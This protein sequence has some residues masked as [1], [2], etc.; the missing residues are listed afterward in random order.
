[1]TNKKVKI[2]KGRQFK[3][4][5]SLIITTILFISVYVALYIL[6]SIVASWWGEPDASD[7]LGLVFVV[8][9][10]VPLIYAMFIKYEK[11]GIKI[12][13]KDYSSLFKMVKEVSDDVGVKMPS[14]IRLLPT[15]EIYV[16]GVFKKHI[17]IGIVALR[18][19][20]KEQL[21]AILYHEFGHFYGN[22][23]VIGFMLANIQISLEKSSKFGKAWWENMP[24]MELALVGVFISLFAKI[25]SFI[26]RTII[27]IYSRQVEY[28]ADCVASTFSKPDVFGKALLNYSAYTIYFGQ[29]GY[30]SIVAMLQEGKAYK[31][32]YEVISEDYKGQKPEKV[33]AIILKSDKGHFFSSH[34]SLKSRIKAIGSNISK[35]KIDVRPSANSLSLINKPKKLEEEFTKS[36]TNH[37]H[38]NLLYQDA[39]AR[40][41]MCK[42]CEEQFEKLE[43]L[44][45]H[46]ARC[47]GRP[48]EER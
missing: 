46:E 21:K 47:K 23:T 16:T 4:Y 45:E 28:R 3:V 40:E 8:I 14:E 39:V 6:G 13:K 26:F 37:M 25:Y 20:P 29:I 5:L 11:G 44:L 31:D 41:G 34:P 22:D 10:F 15:D 12:S 30:N 1:M 36:L 48:K 19:L 18:I 27:S 32:I 9:G 2:S 17:G 43:D 7:F 35:F 33:K 42:Y 24:F 38:V